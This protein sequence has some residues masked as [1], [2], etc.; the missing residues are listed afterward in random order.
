MR[1]ETQ[2]NQSYPI[3]NHRYA[4][5][6]RKTQIIRRKTQKT[7]ENPRSG[8]KLPGLAPLAK[9]FWKYQKR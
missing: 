1:R 6:S 3:L 2:F 5:K 4:V 8:S 9:S 7:M